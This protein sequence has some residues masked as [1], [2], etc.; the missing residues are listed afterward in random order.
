M[1]VSSDAKPIFLLVSVNF[2]LQNLHKILRKIFQRIFP[3]LDFLTP[4]NKENPSK[5]GVYVELHLMRL[6][7]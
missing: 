6:R 2:G 1:G 7:A 5:I 3:S 4:H